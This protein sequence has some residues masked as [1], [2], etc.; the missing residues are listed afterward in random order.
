MP[1]GGGDLAPFSLRIGAEIEE[2][3]RE[4]LRQV[5]NCRPGQR[6]QRQPARMAGLVGSGQQAAGAEV[7]E[8]AGESSQRQG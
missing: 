5:D 6:G 1:W 2:S 7:E 8:H 3:F 4:H